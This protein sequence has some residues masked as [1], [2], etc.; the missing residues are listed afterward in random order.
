MGNVEIDRQMRNVERINFYLVVCNNNP[1]PESVPNSMNVFSA[2]A[3][4]IPDP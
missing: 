1:Q 3:F 4:N 2:T